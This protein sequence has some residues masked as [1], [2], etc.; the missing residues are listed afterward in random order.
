MINVESLFFF[1]KFVNF[2]W[3]QASIKLV[4][5]VPHNFNMYLGSKIIAIPIVSWITNQYFSNLTTIFE[6]I[7]L[8]VTIE[9]LCYWCKESFVSC[10]IGNKTLVVEYCVLENISIILLKLSTYY[11]EVNPLTLTKNKK[12]NK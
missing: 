12:E 1:V 10:I 8:I 7:F 9:Q 6:V 4:R 2:N 5:K 3:R 11:N